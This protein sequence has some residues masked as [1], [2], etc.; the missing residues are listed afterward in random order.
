LLQDFHADGLTVRLDGMIEE[1]GNGREVSL[2]FKAPDMV[3]RPSPEVLLLWLLRYRS[4]EGLAPG[5]Q[6]IGHKPNDIGIEPARYRNV[7]QIIATVV[8]QCSPFY[9]LIRPTHLLVVV[10]TIYNPGR[11]SQVI[12]ESN[13]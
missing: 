10:N 11:Y 6:L 4:R 2:L 7:H 5:F 9:Q 3:T 13:K 8:H 12:E 1:G